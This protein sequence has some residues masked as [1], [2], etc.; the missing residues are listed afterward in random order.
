MTA[1]FLIC[2]SFLVFHPGE[3]LDNIQKEDKRNRSQP[4]VDHNIRD[5]PPSALR[6]AHISGYEPPLHVWT[7]TQ[8]GKREV[9][10][11]LLGRGHI[12]DSTTGKN[13]LVKTQNYPSG[14]LLGFLRP[15]A[16]TSP[17]NGL[18]CV[19]NLNLE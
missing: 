12:Y 8:E 4:A 16:T 7:D 15:S 5:P 17:L 1:L 9:K 6:C 18:E 11:Q 2:I 13:P 3:V 14:K 19:I 10:N